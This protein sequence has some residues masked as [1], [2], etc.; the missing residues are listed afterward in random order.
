MDNILVILFSDIV[1][2]ERKNGMENIHEVVV[3]VKSVEDLSGTLNLE[4][5]HHK[6]KFSAVLACI[7]CLY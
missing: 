3:W 7:P 4:A 6:N 5:C 1:Q 2:K